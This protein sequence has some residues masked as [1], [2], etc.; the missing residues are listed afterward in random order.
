MKAVILAGG[1]GTRISEE[2]HRVPKPM[3]EIGDKPI[4]VHIMKMYSQCGINDF[5]ICAGYK[6]QIIKEYFSNYLLHNSDITF[7]FRESS[8][9]VHSNTAEPWTVTVADTGLMTQTGGRVKKIKKYVRDEAFCLTYGDGVSD[10]PLDKVVDFHKKERKIATITAIRPEGRFGI[11]DLEGNRIRAFREKSREDT[12]WTNGGFMVL[13][14]GVFDYIND[15]DQCVF[16]E[17]PIR[18]LAKDGELNAYRHFGF[19]QC[20]DTL[21]D[22]ERLQKLWAS[23]DAPWKTW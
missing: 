3:L 4:I 9:I 17:E 22:K 2:S 16:E 7:D 11:V 20:M 5:I 6:Q 14:P 8:T 19:W 10:V 23:G 21:R 12:G 15:D 18:K 13:E 1:L